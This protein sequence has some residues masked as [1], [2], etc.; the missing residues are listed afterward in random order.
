MYLEE[1]YNYKNQIL[2]D[3]L[4]NETIVGLLNEDPHNIVYDG[5]ALMYDQVFP[6]EYVPETVEHSKTYI[7]I[8]VDVENQDLNK[9]FLNGRIMVWVF[10]HKSLM[11]L[12]EGGVRVDKLCNEID[13]AINGSRKYGL[14]QLNLLSS[15]RFAIMTDYQ[16]K[17]LTFYTTDFNRVHD[18]KKHPLPANRRFG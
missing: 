5:E 6:Y 17:V 15:K 14:G 18:P 9:T 13:K 12:P 11:R 8:D 4:T 7:C 3:L 16:G 10:T 1:F 2:E